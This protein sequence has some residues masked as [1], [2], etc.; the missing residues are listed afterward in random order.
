MGPLERYL[1]LN[2]VIMVGRTGVLLRRGRNTREVDIEKKP[3]E[4]TAQKER[5]WGGH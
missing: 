1:K 5:G 4:D 2:E 3:H